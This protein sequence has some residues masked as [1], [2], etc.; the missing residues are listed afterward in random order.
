LIALKLSW[1]NFSY[2]VFSHF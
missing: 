2:R 1:T